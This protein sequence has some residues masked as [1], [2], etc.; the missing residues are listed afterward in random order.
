MQPKLMPAKAQLH[1]PILWGLLTIKSLLHVLAIINGYGIH[2]DEFLYLAMGD[3]P[4]L[5]Y[6]ECSPMIGWV[7]KIM[8][9]CTAGKKWWPK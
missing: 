8:P 3:H 1:Y 9:T 7:A 5:G 2:R 4:M 6:L